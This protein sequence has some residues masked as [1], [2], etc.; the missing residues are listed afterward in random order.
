MKRPIECGPGFRNQAVATIA[1]LAIIASSIVA[2]SIVAGR[3]AVGEVARDGRSRAQALTAETASAA[4]QDD[5]VRA[6]TGPDT[7]TVGDTKIA[8]QVL[9]ESRTVVVILTADGKQFLDRATVTAIS[10]ELDANA[11]KVFARFSESAKTATQ[12]RKLVDFA[13]RSKLVVEERQCWREILRLEPSDDEARLGLGHAKLDGKWLEESEVELKLAAGFELREGALVAKAD[14]PPVD[15]DGSSS[16]TR[17]VVENVDAPPPNIRILARTKLSAGEAAKI[18]EARASRT[19]NAEKFRERLAKEYRAGVWNDHSTKNFIIQSNSTIDVARKYGAIMEIVRSKL[20]TMFRSKVLKRIKAPVRI[21]ANQEDFVSSDPLGQWMGRGLGGYYRPDNQSITTYHGTFGFTGTTFSVLAHEGTH[22][23]QGLVLTGGFDN[24]P[25]WLI[26]GLAVYFGDGS[27]FEPEDRK[28]TIGLIPRDRLDHLQEK[29]GAKRHTKIEKLVSMSRYDGFSGSHYA[30]AWGLIYF[31]VNHPSKNGEKLLQ[32]YWAIGLER[33]LTK[34]D[35]LDLVDRYFGSIEDIE[36]QYVEYILSLKAPAV[37]EI[38]GD[39]FVSDTFQFEFKAPSTEWEF[40]EDAKDK[41]LLVGMLK[42]GASAQVRLY[43]ENNIENKKAPEY[44]E[45]WLKENSRFEKL[46]HEKTTIAGLPGY[47]VTYT[48]TGERT[49]GWTLVRGDDGKIIVIG[50]DG[51]D[52]DDD[53][54]DDE[55]PDAGDPEGKDADGKK[56]GKKKKER[57]DV[58]KYLLI[59]VD[60]VASIECSTAEGQLDGYRS[61]FDRM[62][63]NFNLI[64]MRRW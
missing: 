30:D 55:G 4:P 9:D 52:D 37:G 62:N 36:T 11:L 20:A 47:K 51:D 24:L 53:D 50:G 46:R 25:I 10:R 6:N 21:H 13:K 23:F 44:F 54:D 61:V 39:Y 49:T 60:G 63:S 19:E 64:L 15:P 26:E 16:E 57:R 34:T 56:D 41:K 45:D 1:F 28:I 14:K 17:T 2:S 32:Q 35:F 31:L 33:K 42:P 59:Q 5:T 48:D 22:Y 40:F 12:W 7:V 38:R 43:Y 18:E 27:K 3:K 58:I 8:C 29:M